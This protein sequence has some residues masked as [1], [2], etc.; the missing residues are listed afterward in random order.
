MSHAYALRAGNAGPVFDGSD[1]DV[2]TLGADGKAS[3]QA[4]VVDSGDHKVKVTEDDTTPRFLVNKIVNGAGILFS[5]ENPSADELLRV[6]LLA[7]PFRA[8]FW[9][10][11]T[12]TRTET[13]SSSNPFLTI[14]AAFAFAATQGITSGII[15]LPPNAQVTENVTFPAGGGNWEIA[16]QA[17][18]GNY[19]PAG[20]IGNVDGSTSTTARRALTNLTVTG[21]ISGLASGGAASRFALQNVSVS[22]TTTLT[23]SGGA[24]WRLF[25]N[26]W[27][28]GSRTGF[29]NF[30][31]CTLTGAVSVA[32]SVHAQCTGF[33]TSL[34]LAQSSQ[35]T[36]CPMPASI[37]TTAAISVWLNSCSNFTGGAMTYTVAAGTIIKPDGATMR[38][39]MRSSVI[40]SGTGTLE[41]QDA[42]QSVRS[43]IANNVGTTAL[44]A[45]TPAGQ[46]EVLADLTLL[47][48]GTNGS[49]VVNVTY[50]DMTG[51]LVT[52]AI[53]VGLNITSAAGTKAR[54][55]LVFNSNGAT[56][57][58]YSVT[59]IVTPG[60]LSLALA[61]SVQQKS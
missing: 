11:P 59:G 40:I 39:M 14:A 60:A 51:T 27:P 10:D 26:S 48:A 5:L 56:A 3:F 58:S 32:G 24:T 23:T 38:E 16:T 30:P 36:E 47:V 34:S 1:G 44:A 20:I 33:A 12:S 29:T 19:A 41:L 13:G 53:N 37:T 52:E 15:Y 35:F 8:S 46:F 6:S 4:P 55:A 54:G 31:I 28:G 17:T 22:G 9:V 57:I 25:T 45:R 50:T 43:T 42:N 61:V 2:L 18:L 49:A 7:P 21:N